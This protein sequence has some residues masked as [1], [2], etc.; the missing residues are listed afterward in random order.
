MGKEYCKKRQ[1]NE[2][3]EKKDGGD[4]AK[5]KMAETNTVTHINC[6]SIMPSYHVAAGQRKGLRKQTRRKQGRRKK[7]AGKKD[8]ENEYGYI[9]QPPLAHNVV[10]SQRKRHRK[11]NT[12]KGEYP[13]K[14][15]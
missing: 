5:T 2:Y 10:A 12:P 9:T 15:T 8:S 1:R 11:R 13:K 14:M 7:A 3:G 4:I 6:L